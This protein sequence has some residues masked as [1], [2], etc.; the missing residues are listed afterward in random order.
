MA[1]DLW[2]F[3]ALEQIRF[4]LLD[5]VMHIITLL[6]DNA[7]IWI[8]LA[9]VLLS[10]K[11]TRRAGFAVALAL[12]FS[13]VLSNLLLKNIIERARPFDALDGL[14]IIALTTPPSGFSF[15]SGHAS[16]SIAA[17]V[18]CLR[19][20]KNTTLPRCV[21]VSAVIFAV[22][23]AFSRI[24]LH[25]HYLT[26]VLGGIAIGTLCGFAAAAFTIRF[27]KP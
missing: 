1:I 15:P 26:D 3:D 19:A 2:V 7:F 16:A 9:A 20:S 13:G 17:A 6:G 27:R 22:L 24:Y 25:V 10:V 5:R 23:I 18:A 12:V 14:S 8:I 11:R 21:L 4:P